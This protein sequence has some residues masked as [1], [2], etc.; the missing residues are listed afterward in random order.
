MGNHLAKLTPYRRSFAQLDTT[1]SELIVGE[2]IRESTETNDEQLT[3]LKSQ[4]TSTLNDEESENLNGHDDTDGLTNGHSSNGHSSNGHSSN[5]HSSNGQSTNGHS[6]NGHSVVDNEDKVEDNN[7]E[8]NDQLIE[9]SE[10]LNK[11]L[12]GKVSKR[13]SKK[14]NLIEEDLDKD[15]VDEDEEYELVGRKKRGKRATTTTKKQYKKRK[16]NLLNDLQRAS[17]VAINE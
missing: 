8:L 11:D 16:N 12:I 7:E 14:V 6:S 15:E 4:V 17:D 5:G 3:N 10:D 9:V 2:E 13:Q 1:T